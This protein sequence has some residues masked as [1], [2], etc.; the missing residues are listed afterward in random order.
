MEISNDNPFILAWFNRVYNK[1]YYEWND[2]YTT[3]NMIFI[4]NNRWQKDKKPTEEIAKAKI[5][6]FCR[7]NQKLIKYNKCNKVK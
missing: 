3:H 7:L 1:N 5:E 2:K 6:K 4:T